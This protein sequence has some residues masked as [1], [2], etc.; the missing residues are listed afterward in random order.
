VPTQG[1][2]SGEAQ[3]GEPVLQPARGKLGLK[4]QFNKRRALWVA[5]LV[6]CGLGVL[7]GTL[8]WWLNPGLD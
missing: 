7:A 6:L 4:Q 1:D 3:A 8:W 5:V 2:F